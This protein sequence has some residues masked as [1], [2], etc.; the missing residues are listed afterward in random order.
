VQDPNNFE[1]YDPGGISAHSAPMRTVRKAAPEPFTPRGILAGHLASLIP[2]LPQATLEVAADGLTTLGYRRPD[3]TA[4]LALL[5]EHSFTEE[6]GGD[7]WNEP[8]SCRYVCSC[9]KVEYAAW[10]QTDPEMTGLSEFQQESRLDAT[11]LHH[12][13]VASVLTNTATEDVPKPECYPVLTE[14]AIE[15]GANQLRSQIGDFTSPDILMRK[16]SKFVLRAAL[17]YLGVEP[18]R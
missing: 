7:V 3:Y 11:D 16:R 12:A 9:R 8:R 2:A 18:A 4:T 1:A 15:A 5:S 14:S 13:H 6:D 10:M 17:P